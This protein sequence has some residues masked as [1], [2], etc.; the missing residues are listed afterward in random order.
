[1]AELVRQHGLDLARAQARQQGVE[2]DDR[3]APKPVK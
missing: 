1:V 3:L 2:E